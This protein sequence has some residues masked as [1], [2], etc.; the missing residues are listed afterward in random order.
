MLLD[1]YKEK[2]GTSSLRPF[3]WELHANAA[4]IMPRNI[5]LFAESDLCFPFVWISTSISSP[6]SDISDRGKLHPEYRV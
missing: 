3:F 2:P 6:N 4:L 1:L 5:F